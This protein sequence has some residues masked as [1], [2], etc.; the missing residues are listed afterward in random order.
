MHFPRK[1]RG[2]H[3][4]LTASRAMRPSHV[5]VTQSSLDGWVSLL[6]TSSSLRPF[7]KR[8]GFHLLHSRSCSHGSFP[9]LS[10]VTHHIHNYE[11]S[12]G[13]HHGLS[14]LSCKGADLERN[15]WYGMGSFLGITEL[16]KPPLFS[17]VVFLVS[18]RSMEYYYSL[19]SNWSHPTSSRR[20][21]SPL[22]RIP[23]PIDKCE[24]R[25]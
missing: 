15:F 6:T 25:K 9:K 16:W 7:D 23:K 17:S 13:Y 4:Y 22:V 21:Y 18:N 11:G 14:H 12:H 5:S 10:F 19:H 8:R 20:G 3:W 2:R 1:G 24:K